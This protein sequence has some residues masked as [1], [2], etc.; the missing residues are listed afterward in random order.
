MREVEIVKR[1][2]HG[3]ISDPYSIEAAASVGDALSLTSSRVGTLVVVDGDRRLQ[4]LLTERD[5]RFV[6]DRNARVADQDDADGSVS[7]SSWAA[8]ARRGGARDVRAQGQEAA[9]L[10]PAAASSG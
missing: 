8:Q 7:R 5:V 3:V 6:T 2:Q 1:T 4:G 10:T 9:S